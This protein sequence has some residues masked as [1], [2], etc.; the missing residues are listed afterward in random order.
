MKAQSFRTKIQ[1]EQKLSIRRLISTKDNH[2]LIPLFPEY[3]IGQP[4]SVEGR[5]LPVTTHELAA[6]LMSMRC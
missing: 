6:C 5:N 1:S 3:F 4:L 2:P